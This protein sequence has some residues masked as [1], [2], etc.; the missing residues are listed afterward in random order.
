YTSN[1][2]LKRSYQVKDDSRKSM[3]MQAKSYTEIYR[4]LGWLHSKEDVALNF[5]FT[6]LGVHV[7]MS[8]DASKD[9]FAQCLLGI[10]YPNKNLDVKF[11]DSNKP[12]VSIL[13]FANKLDNKINR[14]EILLGP[15]NM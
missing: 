2:I 6:Y 12:F 3:K 4:L 7:A 14:D 10:T 15:M 5:N 1:E 11:K 13:K 8:G 9:L